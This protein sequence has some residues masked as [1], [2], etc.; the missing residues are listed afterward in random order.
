MGILGSLV[1]LALFG[2]F[3]FAVGSAVDEDDGGFWG[4]LI[5]LVVGVLLFTWY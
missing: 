2:W 4:L 5:A 1:S 3:G